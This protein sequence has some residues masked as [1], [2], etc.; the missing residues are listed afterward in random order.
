MKT[1]LHKIDASGESLGRLASKIAILLRGKD[2]PNF[3]HNIMPDTKVE[4]INLKKLKFTGNKLENKIYYRYSGYPGGIYARNLSESFARDPEKLL[5]TT[6]L[7]MLPK[8]RM[9]S[10]IIRNLIVKS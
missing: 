9:R 5:K 3:Q 1:I 6:V 10:K 7:A 8:N 4:V 2:Q